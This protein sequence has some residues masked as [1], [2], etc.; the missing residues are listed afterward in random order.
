MNAP[1]PRP[2]KSH[3]LLFHIERFSFLCWRGTKL[4]FFST[5]IPPCCQYVVSLKVDG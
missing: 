2:S 4:S 1:S 3:T 5:L